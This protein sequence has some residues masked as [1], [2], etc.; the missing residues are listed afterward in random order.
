MGL[1]GIILSFLPKEIMSYMEIGAYSVIAAVILQILGACYFALSMVNW[2]AKSNLIGGIY[3][4]PIAIGNFCHFAMGA[5]ALIK[6]FFS[7]HALVLLAM[8][9]IYSIFAICFAIV[10]FSHPVKQDK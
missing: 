3:S 8:G 6:G 9:L 2:T 10:L 5:L 7:D 4:R 1:A